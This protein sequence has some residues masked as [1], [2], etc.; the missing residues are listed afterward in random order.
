MSK[1]HPLFG[2][3]N[4]TLTP[5]IAGAADDVERHHARLILDDIE[6]WQQGRPLL[7]AAASPRLE[8]GHS[9]ETHA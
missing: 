4:V 3:P 1:D 8:P 6:R 9:E 7:N 5:H 2:F